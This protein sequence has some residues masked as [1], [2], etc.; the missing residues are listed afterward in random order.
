MTLAEALE[1]VSH[2]RLMRLL[3]AEW[4]GHPLLEH[5]CRTL[6]VWEQGYLILS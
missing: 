6:C 5:A 3:R 2:N 4:S 1:T